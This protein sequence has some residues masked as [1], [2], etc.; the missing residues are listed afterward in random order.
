MKIHFLGQKNT[1]FFNVFKTKK[2]QKTKYIE[3]TLKIHGN[4]LKLHF[5]QKYIENTLKN[6]LKLHRNTLK[7]HRNTLKLQGHFTSV[8]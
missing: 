5:K 8:I 6:T 7:I 1:I 3:I 2:V 4:T